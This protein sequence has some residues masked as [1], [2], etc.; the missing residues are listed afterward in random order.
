MPPDE[1][2]RGAFGRLLH[3]RRGAAPPPVFV[4]SPELQERYLNQWEATIQAMRLDT[5]PKNS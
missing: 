4:P 1:E 5:A 3:R 2:S